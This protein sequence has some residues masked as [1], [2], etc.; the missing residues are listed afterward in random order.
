MNPDPFLISPVLGNVLFGSG[1][2]GFVFSIQSFSEMYAK[3]FKSIDP[4]KL[5]KVFWGDFYFDAEA[6]KFAKKVGK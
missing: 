6:K 2:Y 1:E 5:V 3:K 4:T